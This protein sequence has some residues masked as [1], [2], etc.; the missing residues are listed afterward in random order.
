ML[1]IRC[2]IENHRSIK[3]QAIL[4]LAIVLPILAVILAAVVALGPLVY[5]HIATQQASFDCAV[6][7]AQ[8]LDESQGYMQG[9]YAAQASFGSFNVNPGRADISVRGNWD[10]NGMVVCEIAF[11]V[12][13]GAFPFHAV[14]SPPSVVRYSTSLPTHVYKSK[15][16]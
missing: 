7:A 15:W 4:E 3:A 10:R 6:A 12:P 11:S 16:R 5:M 1:R 8:S 13:T 9:I 2:G 14:L